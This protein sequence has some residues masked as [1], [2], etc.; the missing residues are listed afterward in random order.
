MIPNKKQ[1]SIELSKI[2]EV[3]H[4]NVSLEQY[5]T[6]LKTAVDFLYFSYENGGIYNKTVADLGCGNGILGIGAKLLGAKTVDFYD[7]DQ[8]AVDVCEENLLSLKIKSDVYRSDF[9]DITKNYDTIISNPPFGIRTSFDPALFIEKIK[10][11]SSNFFIILP[12]NKRTLEISEKEGTLLHKLGDISI[13]AFASG[14]K[15][16]IFKVPVVIVYSIKV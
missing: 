16:E 11:I 15:K 3:E 4:K 7:I 2:N 13:P 1:L 10:T 9:F 5:Q 6:D 8:K 14:H 12:E